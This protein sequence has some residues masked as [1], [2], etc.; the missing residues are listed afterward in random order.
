MD[1]RLRSANALTHPLEHTAYQADDVISGEPTVG[2]LALGVVGEVEVGL[3]EMSAGVARDTEVDEVFVV[4]SGAGSVEFEDGEV[5]E[6]AP[7]VVVALA[8]GERTVWSITAP[9]RKVYVA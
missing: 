6:L 2:S 3:W 1:P 5:I 7:G 4:L 8:A 9:L